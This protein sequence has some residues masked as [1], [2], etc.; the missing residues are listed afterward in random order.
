[1]RLTEFMRDKMRSFLRITEAPNSTIN[2]EELMGF[3]LNVIKNKIWYEGDS[4][5]LDQLYKQLPHG[6]DGIKFWGAT[7]TPNLALRKLHTGLP[8]M[9]VDQLTGIVLSDMNDIELKVPT[10]QETWG[11][12]A[13]SNKFNELLEE[14]VSMALALGDVCFKVSLDSSVCKYPIIEVHTPDMFEIVYKRSRMTEVIFR[15][16]YTHNG[17]VYT[18]EET[19]GY[20]YISYKLYRD[21]KEINIA[22]I[23]QTKHL[24]NVVF[25]KACCM[26]LP[27]M[28]YKDKKHKGRGKS[29]FDRKIDAFDA[30]DEVVSQ[31]MDA[32]RKGRTKEYIPEELIPRDEKNGALLKPNAFDNSFLQVQSSMPEDGIQ[33]I[34]VETPII[35]HD[36]LL[37]TYVTILDLCLQGIIS[38]ST[39]GIDVKKLDNA[40][41]QREKEKATLYTR[42]KIVG[43]LQE[44]LP[45]LLDIVFKVIAV[46]DKGPLRDI[47]C[48]VAFGEYANPSFESQVETVG[49][50]KTQGIMSIEAS[51]EELYGDTKDKVWKEK[52]VARLKAEQG[53]VEM[54]EP[55]V[56]IMASKE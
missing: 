9:I 23:P 32:I 21:D 50:A 11:K 28:I 56:G 17:R 48:T 38:P 16:E 19:Y 45:S 49:K 25:D 35:Q 3:D 43:A 37:N 12:I 41:A 1:M 46:R 8:G 53:I 24:T 29:I 18:L 44:Q 36:A 52:E 55:E 26:A 51:V 7:Q 2:I 34:Q 6:A 5:S 47:G 31:W 30:F 15:N 54:E 40:E 27:F 39:L 22:A 33:K 20:G 10:D 42:N 13:E 14:A 4:Y